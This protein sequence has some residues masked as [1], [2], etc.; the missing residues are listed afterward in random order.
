MDINYEELPLSENDLGWINAG[1]GELQRVI[2]ELGVNNDGLI[3]PQILDEVYP[4]FKKGTRWSKKNRTYAIS[5]LGSG[6]GYCYIK[7]LGYKWIIVKDKMGEE[8][9]VKHEESNWTNF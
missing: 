1:I 8:F 9:A 7:E 4:F 5:I 6:L 2:K 3:T